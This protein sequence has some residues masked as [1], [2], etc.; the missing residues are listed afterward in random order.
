[1]HTV[2]IN[3]ILIVECWAQ[4]KQSCSQM[5]SKH[6]VG[7]QVTGKPLYFDEVLTYTA[8]SNIQPS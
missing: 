6:Q 2:L 3:S 7:K 4:T 1:M 5:V 8:N